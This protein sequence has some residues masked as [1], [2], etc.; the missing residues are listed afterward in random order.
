MRGRNNSSRSTRERCRRAAGPQERGEII[1]AGAH[2]RL[3]KKWR[4][5]T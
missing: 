3:R 2:K 4:R 5:S 1:A